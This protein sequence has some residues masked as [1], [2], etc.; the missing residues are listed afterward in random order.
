MPTGLLFECDEQVAKWTYSYWNAFAL[1]YNKAIGLVDNEGNLIGGVLFQN[2]NGPNIELSYYGEKTM[3]PGIVRAIARV[4]LNEFDVARI[5]ALTSKKNRRFIRGLFK[6]G[7]RLEGMQRCFYG[8]R[9]C[10]RNTAVRCVAF[11]EQIEK[12]AKWSSNANGPSPPILAK[13]D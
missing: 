12:V 7:F 13:R 6:L 3:T 11:R 5:T 1:P 10:N 9:D 4:A 2:W 8:K